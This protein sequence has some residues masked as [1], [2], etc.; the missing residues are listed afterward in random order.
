[1]IL[2]PVQVQQLRQKRD[3]LHARSAEQFRIGHDEQANRNADAAD[4]ITR[5]L[6]RH[7]AEREAMLVSLLDHYPEL[8]DDE[9]RAGGGIVTRCRTIRILGLTIEQAG[10]QYSRVRSFLSDFGIPNEMI[11]WHVRD[12]FMHTIS[13]GLSEGATT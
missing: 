2:F 6:D 1:M 7:Y 8:S 3:A 11:E 10:A 5:K 9:I 13:S 12:A 4:R